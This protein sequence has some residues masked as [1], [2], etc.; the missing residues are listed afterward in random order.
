LHKRMFF[1]ALDRSGLSGDSHWPAV[2][3]SGFAGV[4]MSRTRRTRLDFLVPGI[5]FFSVGFFL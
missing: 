5:F 4:D 2:L 3:D 1:E